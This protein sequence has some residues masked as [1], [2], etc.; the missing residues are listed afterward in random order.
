MAETMIVVFIDRAGENQMPKRHLRSYFTVVGIE[1]HFNQ[2]M[3][4]H[5]L[6][7]R[8]IA[9]FWQ[10]LELLREITIVAVRPDRD[11]PTHRRIEVPRVALPLFARVIFEKHFVQL[12]SYLGN[13]HLF[14]VFWIVDCNA[15]LGELR[16]HFLAGRW[17]PNKLLESVEVNRELPEAAVSP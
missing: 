11:P 12:P 1:P 16:L 3:L 15:P 5:F 8:G 13:D 17:P 14:G 2:R 10:G 6:E 7:H 4:Q 9:V